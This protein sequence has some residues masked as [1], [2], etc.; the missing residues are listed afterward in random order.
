MAGPE[1]LAE[2][3]LDAQVAFVLAELEGERLEATIARDVPDL[4]ALADALVV[5]EAL[6]ADHV[7]AT[8]H[9][10]V[11]MVGDSPLIE[12]MASEVA[13]AIYKLAAADDNELGEVIDREHA[14][15]LIRKALAMRGFRDKAL[16]RL[17][18]SPVVATV[19][20]WFVNKIVTDFVAANTK[21]AERLPGM[22]MALG[23]G[24]RAA[25]VARGQADRHLGDVI[26]DV[27]GKGAQIALRRLNKAIRETMDEAPLHAAA[28]EIWDLHAGEPISNLRDYLSAAD[29]QDFVAINHQIWLTLRDTEYFAATVDAAIDVFFANYGS[30]TVGSLLDELGVDR[31]HLATDAALV[32]PPLL[33]AVRA[34]GLLEPFVRERLEPF[35][36]SEE[37]LALLA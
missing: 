6:S 1:G 35:W 34:S 20:S 14:E 4:L 13:D 26:G 3:L 17:G 8:A 31:A 37:A 11:A 2:R 15:A 10:Y 25:E 16:E 12:L 36:R 24:R 19:A 32:V 21:R 30:R 22:G 5:A 29:L 7:K 27:A 9:R 28:M 18:E 23:A 33:E